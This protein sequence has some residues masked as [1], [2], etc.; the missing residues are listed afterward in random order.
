MDVL[1]ENTS[2]D[3][4]ADSAYRS[5]VNEEK[6]A[7]RGLRSHI[8]RK[9]HLPAAGRARIA[10]KIGLMNLVYNMRRLVQ[11]DKLRASGV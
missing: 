11:I 10:T 9:G 3:L 2:C 6:L 5:Q 8:Y 1:S 7:A 4:W